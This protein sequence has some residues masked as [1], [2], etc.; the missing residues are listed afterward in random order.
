MAKFI[1]CHP[2]SLEEEVS[3][4]DYDDNNQ[5]F[6]ANFVTDKFEFEMM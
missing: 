3:L 6:M 2:L 4:L 1:F 5:V